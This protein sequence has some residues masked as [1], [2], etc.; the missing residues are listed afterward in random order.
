MSDGETDIR[1]L[2]LRRKQER[3]QS[4]VSSGHSAYE[5][6]PIK[7][8]NRTDSSRSNSRRNS[9]VEVTP[10]LLEEEI[11][12]GRMHVPPVITC[13]CNGSEA[14]A[15]ISS[16]EPV[17]TMS[18]NFLRK[19]RLQDQVVPDTGHVFDSFS[20]QQQKELKGKVKYIDL[21]IGSTWQQWKIT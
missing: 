10:R 5:A 2:A 21:S 20:L 17:S 11:H 3:R 6:T 19:L 7:E 16:S 13:E 8:Y 18:A 4:R 14:F 15:H 9:Y 1:L 12:I